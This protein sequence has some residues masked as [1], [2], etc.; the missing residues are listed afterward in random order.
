MH[1][2]LSMSS[3]TKLP[4]LPLA[5]PPSEL[6]LLTRSTRKMN[7]GLPANRHKPTSNMA[8][9]SSGQPAP[10]SVPPFPPDQIRDSVSRAVH[11]SLIRLCGG[12][13]IGRTD[14]T[15]ST[16]WHQAL[17][18]L[19]A[20][21]M[22]FT[23]GGKLGGDASDN[24][25][26]KPHDIEVR[27]ALSLF[28]EYRR[29]ARKRTKIGDANECT[30]HNNRTEENEHKFVATEEVPLQIVSDLDLCRPINS[31]GEL[32]KLIALDMEQHLQDVEESRTDDGNSPSTSLGAICDDIRPAA[33]SGILCLTTKHRVQQLRHN[34]KLPCPICIK[35]CNGEKG[36][37]WH[38]QAEH[39][40][41]HG[42]AMED[43][44]NAVDTLAMVV[45]DP[46]MAAIIPA[47]EPRRNVSSSSDENNKRNDPF[48]CAKSGDLTSLVRSLRGTGLDPAAAIDAN[49]S[50]CLHWAAGGGH[51]DMVKHLIESCGC[52]PNVGQEGKR[53][54]RDRTALHWAA[55][56]GHLNVVQY[57]LEECNADIEASTVDGTTAFC[58]AS[59]QGHLEVMQY[60]HSRGCNINAIN[61]FGCNATLWA[62]QGEGGLE[63]MKWLCDDVG[64]DVMRI[65]ENGH[66]IMHK[67]AQRGKQGVIEWV[68]DRTKGKL[69]EA[70]KLI[71]PDLEQHCPSDLA[72][73]EGHA[74]LAEWLS[75]KE[76]YVV[77]QWYDQVAIKDS[78]NISDLPKWLAEGLEKV[79]GMSKLIIGS[80]IQM[81]AWEAGGGIRRICSHITNGDN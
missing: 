18:D 3:M 81:N 14:T 6:V 57:L 12:G 79:Q 70:I 5:P 32:A 68:L 56:N 71:G 26:G 10:P 66:S 69:Y 40:A 54:F 31:A 45:Y 65:N 51:L 80:K 74:E 21:S 7:T 23:N 76:K 33:D 46:A 58:W 9:L 15:S 35:W 48:E 43:A 24:G 30:Q 16:E 49:G 60:L 2:P 27:V 63:T 13:V 36:L 44:T 8:N 67:S 72:G 22:S 50:T 11:S 55:R 61:S 4:R 59:W 29:N 34:G 53:S 39:G 38:R 75:E 37:W 17:Y 62:A 52:C 20:K 78:N 19:A 28:H 42:D 73:M 41:G 77:A 1:T 64:C 47:N 25:G